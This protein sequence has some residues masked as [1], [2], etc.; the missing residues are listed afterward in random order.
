MGFEG[1]DVDDLSVTNDDDKRWC[2]SG[3]KNKMDLDITECTVSSFYSIISILKINFD[4]N[5]SVCRTP[6]YCNI[7]FVAQLFPNFHP[8]ARACIHLKLGHSVQFL[9]KIKSTLL[10]T[11]NMVCPFSFTLK[12]S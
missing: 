1:H 3:F 11:V 9:A 10:A 7:C 12:L 6:S 2:V 5:V 8:S 4:L